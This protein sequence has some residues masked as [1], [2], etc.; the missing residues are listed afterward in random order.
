M[1]LIYKNEDDDISYSV[2]PPG[3]KY[4]AT[5]ENDHKILITDPYYIDNFE[6]LLKDDM[7]TM[8]GKHTVN[9]YG[10]DQKAKNNAW[11]AMPNFI[12]IP[13]LSG[14]RWRSIRIEIDYLNL[15]TNILYNDPYG[16]EGFNDML[17]DIIG[18]LLHKAISQLVRHNLGHDIS[19]YDIQITIN[20]KSINQH[21]RLENV[22]DSGPITFSNIAD[23]ANHKLTNKQFV[24]DENLYTVSSFTTDNIS[25][26]KQILEICAKDV[27]T[28]TG[29]MIERIKQIKQLLK[30]NIEL[31]IQNIED[32]IDPLIITKVRNLPDEECAFIFEI[33]DNERSIEKRDLTSN[34]TTAELNKA[35]N[36]IINKLQITPKRLRFSFYDDIIGSDSNK[37]NNILVEKKCEFNPLQFPI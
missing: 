30:D 23:Y 9:K 3:D 28:M 29:S 15:K 1:I 36:F 6:L 22:Y 13:L 31:K 27:T 32:S 37:I 10:A 14:I 18:P 16:A 8:M 2:K 24:S 25:H 19:T 35:Y 7:K 21:G 4:I 12:I 11:S 33:I 26:D 34:Y 5:R 17:I 20:K